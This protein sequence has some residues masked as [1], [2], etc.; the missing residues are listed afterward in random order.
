MIGYFHNINE[1]APKGRLYRYCKEEG[2]DYR[3]VVAGLRA[4]RHTTIMKIRR[5]L[6]KRE[7]L[8][9]RFGRSDQERKK[10]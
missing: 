3:Y 6:L 2:L 8:S 10:D 1:P 4:E 7:F 9:K 5:W